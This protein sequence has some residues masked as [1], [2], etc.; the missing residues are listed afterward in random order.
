MMLITSM[1][2]KKSTIISNEGN[3]VALPLVVSLNRAS[4]LWRLFG[5]CCSCWCCCCLL[6]ILLSHHNVTR[7][8]HTHV[9]V[10]NHLFIFDENQPFS[11]YQLRLKLFSLL[12]VQRSN[13]LFMYRSGNVIKFS[14]VCPSLS[15][16]LAR[17]IR[18][19]LIHAKKKS[20]ICMKEGQP[21]HVYPYIPD[22]LN[23]YCKNVYRN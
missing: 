19:T 10:S 13:G 3:L 15:F 20:I 8:T 14:C 9:N 1:L 23:K 16:S 11:I 6:L 2:I 12:F 22:W 18:T 17:C 21:A 5:V 4:F 7:Y